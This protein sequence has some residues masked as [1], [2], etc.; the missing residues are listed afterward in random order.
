M[1]KSNL[2]IIQNSFAIY[3]FISLKTFELRLLFSYLNYQ[4]SNLFYIL[5]IVLAMIFW[6]D[7]YYEYY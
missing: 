6:L 2:R 5:D 3:L 7:I 4:Y 1:T